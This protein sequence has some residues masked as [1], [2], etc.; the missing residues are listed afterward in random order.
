L[1]SNDPMPDNEQLRTAV[2]QK[3]STVIDPETGEDIVHMRLIEDLAVDT[4]GR[5]TYKFRPS[6]AFCP[7]AIPLAD[8]IQQAVATV[9][10][11]TSQDLQIVGLL[12]SEEVAAAIQEAMSA[13]LR[14]EKDK[15]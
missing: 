13:V 9:P 4:Q 15:G 6:S 3:L 2:L 14:Q 8:A 7:I 1:A 10:G 5:V 12:F 11:V